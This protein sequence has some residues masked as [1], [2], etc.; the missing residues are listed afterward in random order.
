MPVIFTKNPA[1]IIGLITAGI[2]L[3][4][5]FGLHLSGVQSAA[6]LA[7]STAA[8]AVIGAVATKSQVYSRDS[9]IVALNAPSSTTIEQLDQKLAKL[10]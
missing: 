1:L 6:I 2:D 9:A 8:I 7:F 4:V 5:A 10:P 3:G